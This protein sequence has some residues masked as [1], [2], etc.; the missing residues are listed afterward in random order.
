MFRAV[1]QALATYREQVEGLLRDTL[2]M[3]APS[4]GAPGAADKVS[5]SDQQPEPEQPQQQQQQTRQLRRQQVRGLIGV[6]PSCCTP[7]HGSVTGRLLSSASAAQRSVEPTPCFSL[8]RP[9]LI[10]R[11]STPFPVFQPRDLY[12]DPVHDRARR[13][14]SCRT[15]SA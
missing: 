14:S 4:G 15:S 9:I 12:P 7:C 10:L 3:L 11:P 13:A 1:P 6:L 2:S 5:F 8:S